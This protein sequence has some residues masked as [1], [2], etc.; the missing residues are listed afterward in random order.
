MSRKNNDPSKVAN[1][2]EQPVNRPERK[3]AP[4]ELGDHKQPARD[5]RE[6]PV[7]NPNGDP[8]DEP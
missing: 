4:P 8:V 2:K 7:P 6:A 3:E 1:P 5:I